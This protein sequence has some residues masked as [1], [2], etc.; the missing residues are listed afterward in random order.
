MSVIS[1]RRERTAAPLL[2]VLVLALVACGPSKPRRYHGEGIVEDVRVE[3]G[4][5]LISH[6]DIPGLMPAMTMSFDVPDRALAARLEPGSVID[7]TLEFDGRSYRIVDARVRDK[8]EPR[9]G[10]ALLGNKLLRA[11]PAPD[12]HLIDQDGHPLSLA[13]LRGRVL[14]LDF[15]FTRCPGP[16][17]I[18]TGLHADV[19]RQIPPDLRP[20]IHFVSISLD[21]AH[22]TPA[23][24]R[25]YAIARGADLAG[26]S[27]LT[28]DAPAIDQVLEAYGIGRS[29]RDDGEIE[30]IVATFLIDAQG[31]IV[32]RYLGLD[33]EPEEILHDL[34]DLAS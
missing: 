7:F 33:H 16:C 29:R 25:D 17:P 14:L 34:E 26:W 21:P 24:L 15:V 18:L 30:H 4:Q 12:F 20:R 8:V 31:R 23:A 13:D 22:D 2:L 28:G 6:E 11:D 1:N 3:E 19:Q 27:F 5:V 32:R 10:Y 9:E